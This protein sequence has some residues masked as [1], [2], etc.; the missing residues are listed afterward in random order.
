MRRD[1][2]SELDIALGHEWR[3]DLKQI[4]VYYT[5]TNNGSSTYSVSGNRLRIAVAE[6]LISW[7]WRPGSTSITDFEYVMKKFVTSVG[8]RNVP[9]LAAGESWSDTLVINTPANV[10][11]YKEIAAVAWIQNDN[12]R[13]VVNAQI[14]HPV[15]IPGEYFDFEAVN[16]SNPGGIV[17]DSEVTPQLRLLNSGTM[18]VNSVKVQAEVNGEIVQTIDWTGELLGGDEQLLTFDN[19]AVDQGG[20]VQVGFNTSDVNAGAV[21]FDVDRF[22]GFPKDADVAFFLSDATIDE[23]FESVGFDDEGIFIVESPYRN[24]FINVVPNSF[25]PPRNRGYQGFSRNSVFVDF[26]DWNP[27]EVDPVAYM[28]TGEVDLT[29]YLDPKLE[30]G[31]SAAQFG[32]SQDELAVEISSDCGASWTRIWSAKGEDL[33]T[34]SRKATRFIPSQRNEWALTTIDLIDHINIPN[35]SLRFVAITDR[36]NSLFLDNIRVSGMLVSNQEYLLEDV[37]VF[38]NPAYDQLTIQL[39]LET[40]EDVKV[41]LIDVTGKIASE[42]YYGSNT[43]F[44]TFNV[45]TNGLQ[46]GLYLVQVTAG[47]YHAIHKVQIIK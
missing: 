9:S 4:A 11:S 25:D 22:N 32:G 42:Q 2:P 13:N 12:T 27:A 30:F 41:Q 34:T 31:R 40:K 24:A 39:S 16:A 7:P 10:Y 14:S 23:G 17:C 20:Y 1:I 18:P 5:V 44:N 6:E 47:K 15:E 19:V 28:S 46:T 3:N 37:S 35:A 21:A 36:G 29:K 33:A 8:G 26:Y 45:H 38:P 43:G